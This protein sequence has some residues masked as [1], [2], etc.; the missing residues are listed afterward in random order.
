V[1]RV[2]TEPAPTPYLTSFGA[3]GINLELG[4]WIADAAT[5]TSAVRS[6]VN[7]NIWQLFSAHGISIPFA[8]R[9]V[10][11]VGNVGHIANV[12]GI[13]PQPVTMT[14]PAANQADNAL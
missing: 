7:R 6:A 2:L 4:F 14:A 5:G 9:E 10:R 11:I 12:S 8:Q 13:A 1:P 3:D